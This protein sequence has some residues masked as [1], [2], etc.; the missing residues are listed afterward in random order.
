ML[1]PRGELV[2]FIACAVILILWGRIDYLL[3]H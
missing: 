2:A 3:A 1:T